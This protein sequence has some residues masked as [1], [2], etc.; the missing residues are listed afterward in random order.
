MAPP[1]HSSM[2]LDDPWLLTEAYAS[3]TLAELGDRIG[4]SAA[5]VR[6]AMIRHGITSQPRNRNR[7]P[8]GADVLDDGHWL[9]DRYRTRTGVE[10]ARELGVSP[11]TV[12]AAMERHGIVRRITPGQLALRRPELTDSDWLHDAVERNSSTDV[13]SALAVSAGSV[14]NAYRR[15][16]IDPAST[17]RLYLRGRAIQRPSAARL[18]SAWKAEGSVRG[19]ARAHRNSPGVLIEFPHLV[20][21]L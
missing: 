4:V 11:R 3:A 6:R 17:P 5:T 18:R 2:L 1:R 13:A 20:R 15:S 9:A 14:T 16:G 19:V 7:R 10:I 21:R 12:Y 8:R